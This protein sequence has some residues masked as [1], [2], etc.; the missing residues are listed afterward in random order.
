MKACLIGPNP[1]DFPFDYANDY[2]QKAMY[3]DKLYKKITDL[4]HKGCKQFITGMELGA[5]LDFANAITYIRDESFPDEGITI[6]GVIAHSNMH[7]EY[8][9][10]NWMTFTGVFKNCDKKTIVSEH[11]TVDCRIK[12]MKYMIDNSD[13]VLAV[14]NGEE[15]GEIWDMLQYAKSLD[16]KIIYVL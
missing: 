16:K 8:T 2:L 5:E 6:E 11:L 14:W 7:K 9:G 13:I 10:E 15:A 4:I 1:N 3:Q 12:S